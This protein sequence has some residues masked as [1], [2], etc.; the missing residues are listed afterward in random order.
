M[1]GF[2]SIP[3]QLI[4]KCAYQA[5]RTY[6]DVGVSPYLISCDDNGSVESQSSLHSLAVPKEVLGLLGDS[7]LAA[8]SAA[9]FVRIGQY[10]S[11]AAELCA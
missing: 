4:L 1:P 2:E 10:H 6:N 9:V 5:R 8:R 7:G 11:K 3:I